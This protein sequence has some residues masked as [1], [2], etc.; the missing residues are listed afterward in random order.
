MKSTLFKDF[1]ER[2]QEVSRY[3]LFLK[4]LEQSSIRLGMGKKN[5][6]IRDIDI[7]LLKTLKAT[8]FLLLYNLVESTMQNE[9]QAIHD[10]IIEENNSFDNLRNELKNII[11]KNFSKNKSAKD[12]AGKIKNIS[13]DI[14]SE[15][16]SSEKMFSGNVNNEIIKN[17]ANSYG[18]SS[19][20]TTK[21]RDGTDLMII[22]NHRND[23][24]HGS[25]SFKEVGRNIT[26]DEL[27]EI[28]K[29]VI[30][31]LKE[32]LLNIENCISNQKYLK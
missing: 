12:L 10:N 16:L 17:L 3:F 9:I 2:S 30:F 6:T 29:R 13:V 1:D 22:K 4:N 7:E 24:A 28:Q 11:I 27:L 26:A 15:G 8:G 18:F 20:T 25:Q 31:Y 14:V 23:L 32:I 19:A 21:T 5:K